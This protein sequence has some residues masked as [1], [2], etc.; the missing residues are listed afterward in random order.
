MAKI[1]KGPTTKSILKPPPAP[2]VVPTP[3]QSNS[4]A[5]TSLVDGYGAF[6]E[7]Q[8]QTPNL[9]GTNEFNFA[10]GLG[11]SGAY[12]PGMYSVQNN[13]VMQNP[14]LSSMSDQMYPNDPSY[15]LAGSTGGSSGSQSFSLAGLLKD[16]DLMAGIQAGTAAFGTGFDIYDKLWGSSAKTAKAQQ[17]L[18]NQQATTNAQ[19]LREHTDFRN[20][21]VKSGLAANA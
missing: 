8:N 9:L 10:N 5:G 7:M 6:K 15:G 20:G 12:E 19:L 18:M 3:V 17:N 1:K 14:A 11:N 16:Q 4:L 21:L 2:L 13:P